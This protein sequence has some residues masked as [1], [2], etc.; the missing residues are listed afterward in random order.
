KEAVEA[1]FRFL[2][3]QKMLLEPACAVCLVPIYRQEPL[4]Q[5][6]QSLHVVLCG[7]NVV[8]LELLHKWRDDPLLRYS[9]RLTKK[10]LAQN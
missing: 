8:T 4:L 5:Q 9:E 1:A 2:D 3:E 7:G 10:P 6:F